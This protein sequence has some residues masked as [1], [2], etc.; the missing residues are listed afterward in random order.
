MAKQK[1]PA[2]ITPNEVTMKPGVYIEEV[3]SASKP[4]IGVP[5]SITAFVG[6]A[7]KGPLN[8]PILIHCFTEYIA[9][10]GGLCKDSN[11]GYAVY[12]FFL[13]GG[14]DALIIRV[15]TPS[16]QAV[17]GSPDQKTGIYALEKAEIFNLLCLPCLDPSDTNRKT[18]YAAAEAFCEQHHAIL[19]IDPSPEWT[20]K[21]AA[22]NAIKTYPKSRNAAAYF[23][24]L[25]AADPLT[26]VEGEF[27][28]SGAVAGVI[29]RT[30]AQRGV[31]VAP[32]GTS[33]TLM[34]VTGLTVS[35]SEGEVSDLN[36]A[37]LNCLR[38]FY[39]VG[40]VVWGAQTLRGSQDG[41][42]KYVP[43]RRLALY[44]EES[45]SLGTQWVTFE[46]NNE[47]LW[48][49][50]RISVD[51]FMHSLWM[52]GAF[53]G[54]KST[55]AYLIKCDAETNTQADLEAGNLNLLVGFA[56]LKPAEF[57][58]LKIQQKTASQTPTATANLPKTLPPK[59]NLTLRKLKP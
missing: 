14:S 9:S 55:E 16:V 12:H 4:I 46:P 11:L 24:R 39:S 54:A 3:S 8:Q 50:I 27:D 30:D 21:T 44:L 49:K 18:I 29:A 59:T 13:N 23:P 6:T 15:D 1:S 26:G 5:T 10:F 48:S 47:A 32:A 51:S 45:L 42:W 7:Q 43:V 58:I 25:K 2:A 38:I 22:L 41:E 52:Q 37:G 40:A 20:N 31:W 33:A 57:V 34:G 56:P 19:L 17:L 53:M 35:L 36:F 28:P